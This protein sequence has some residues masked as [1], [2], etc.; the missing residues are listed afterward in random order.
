MIQLKVEKTRCGEI[1]L[2]IVHPLEKT[3]RSVIFYHGWSSDAHSQ[4][5]RA[6]FLAVQ[7]YTV[8][9]P[10]A[11]NHGERNRLQDYYD[12]SAYDIFWKVIFQNTAEFPAL[13]SLIREQ[14]GGKP[15]V[16]GHSMG[17]MSVLHIAVSYPEQVKGVV[18]F[19]GSGDWRLTHLFMQARFGMYVE[20]DWKSYAEI[21]ACSPVN[22]VEKIKD[23]PVLLTNGEADGSVDPRAQEHF[24][25]VLKGYSHSAERITYP[26][27]GHFVTTNMM[28]DAVRWMESIR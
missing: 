24:F 26:G 16:M 20:D 14:G 1:P 10:D 4:L 6:C 17:G 12:P 28:D 9:V 25:A 8:Y 5:T 18:S 15:F 3:G 7:G 21:K 2:Y 19:N 13:C 23:L 11:M 22:H 27:L